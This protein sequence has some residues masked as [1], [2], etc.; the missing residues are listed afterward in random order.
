MALLYFFSRT[1][2]IMKGDGTMIILYIYFTL[3]LTLFV[4]G[5]IISIKRGNDEIIETLEELKTDYSTA[6]QIIIL[7]II[8][9]YG[10]T[11]FIP[12]IIAETIKRFR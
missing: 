4:V 5:T 9:I 8:A 2:S 7:L 3:S 1:C 12:N 11:L 6:A 10:A